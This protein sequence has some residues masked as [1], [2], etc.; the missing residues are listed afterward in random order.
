MSSSTVCVD[1]SFVVRLFMGPDDLKYWVVFEGW[2]AEG[3][4]IHAPGL[5]AYELANAFYRY[6]HAGYLSLASAELAVDA[7]LGLPIRLE[8]DGALHRAAMRIADTAGRPA[9]YDAYYLGLAERLNAEL[10]TADARLA[11]EASTPRPVIRLI[12]QEV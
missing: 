10:W 1:A 2:C 11:R 3:K 8:T 4:T 9:T 7:A 12:G 5:M 6:H